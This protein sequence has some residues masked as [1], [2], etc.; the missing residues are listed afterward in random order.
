MCD[1]ENF[2]NISK[3][4]TIAKFSVIEFKISEYLQQ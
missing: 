3:K 2:G 4:L 1:K